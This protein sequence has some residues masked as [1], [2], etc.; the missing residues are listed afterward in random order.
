M[1]PIRSHAAGG[2]YHWREYRIDEFFPPTEPGSRVLLL[3]CGDAGE[4]PMLEARG[5]T[6]VGFD[7]RR[8][9]GVDV[10]GDAHKLPFRDASFD[11]VL[12]MQVLEHLRSP[13]LA[14][15]ETARV[16]QPEGWFIGSVAFM[17]PYHGSYFH[18]SHLGVQQLLSTAGLTVDKLAGAQSVT[19]SIYGEMLPFVSRPLRRAVLGAF[20]RLAFKLRASLWS[21]VRRQDPD[22]PSDRYG[23][24]VPLSFRD[25]DR[26]RAAP[27]VVFRA[28]KMQD[29]R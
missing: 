4:R 14:A 8:S 22:R 29:S 1:Q 18:M 26:L 2:A 21:L 13:W 6:V 15:S 12:S 17:K 9:A 5:L 28:R 24:G 25:F 3:G 16:L 20:D 27:A 23:D 19:Y 11:I 7:I 10:L